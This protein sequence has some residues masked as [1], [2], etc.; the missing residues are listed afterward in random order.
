MLLSGQK[1][2]FYYLQQLLI[3]SIKFTSDLTKIKSPIIRQVS[4]FHQIEKRWIF[5]SFFFFEIG[6]KH[7]VFFFVEI[8]KKIEKAL[9]H[10]NLKEF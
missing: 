1:E 3:F 2:F 7:K 8:K 4:F 10:N 9:F 6:L 5:K